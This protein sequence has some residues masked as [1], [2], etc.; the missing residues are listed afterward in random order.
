MKRITYLL[1]ITMS[2][3]VFSNCTKETKF[4]E[5][6]SYISFEAATPTIIVQKGGSTTTDIHIYTTQTSGSDRVF[7][8]EVV[9]ASTTASPDAYTVPATVTV[10]ANSNDGTLMVTVSDNNLGED[11]VTLVLQVTG[12][13]LLIGNQAS[14]DLLLFCPFDPTLTIGSYHAVS[15]GWGVDGNVTITADPADPRK[16]YVTGLETIDGVNEDKGPL[17]LIINDDNSVTVPKTIL[18]SSAFGYTNLAYDGAGVYNTC[19]GSFSL[20]MDVNVDEGY[21]GTY[22]WTLT[23]N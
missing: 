10:P 19:N 9:E 14:L 4:T 2:V 3:F 20:T 8:V 23:P 22:S 1:L 13:D 17:P 7:E 6:L 18:A 12:T 16:V 21:F 11:P 5:N 15:D